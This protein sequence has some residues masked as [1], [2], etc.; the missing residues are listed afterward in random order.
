MASNQMFSQQPEGT[1]LAGQ[2]VESFIRIRLRPPP[3]LHGHTAISL[4]Q[5]AWKVTLELVC[6]YGVEIS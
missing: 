4:V 1:G 3:P 5:K 2:S 6:C